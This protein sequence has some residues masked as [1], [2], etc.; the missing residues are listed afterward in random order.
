MKLSVII[1]VYNVSDTLG[2]CMDSV[3]AQSYDDCEF[4]IIDDGSTDGSSQMCDDYIAKDRRV[5]VFHKE[6]AGLSEARNDGVAMATGEYITFVD[7]DDYIAKDTYKLL[8]RRILSNRDIDILEYP[9]NVHYGNADAH[10]LRFADKVYTDKKEYWFEE[11]AYS[12][13]YMWNKIMKRSLFDGL[14]FPK[15]KKFEDSYIYPHLVDRAKVIAVTGVGMYY[16][17]WNSS[18]ITVTASNKDYDFLLDIHVNNLKRFDE[19]DFGKY[20]FL[21]YYLHILNIQCQVYRSMKGA[22]VLPR[23]KMPFFKNII[24]VIRHKKTSMILKFFTYSIFGV[25]A[26]CR[27]VSIM[28]R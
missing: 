3:L 24:P 17:C 9:V 5:K 4:I 21:C 1:P 27:L 7:S 16:Y 6:N 12:H 14:S 26:T 8:M 19:H 18:G 10:V 23:I 20:G 28:S 25:K 2:R 13:A 22:V 11:S 15:G